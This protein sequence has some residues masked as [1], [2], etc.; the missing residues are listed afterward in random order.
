MLRRADH[1]GVEAEWRGSQ[2]NNANVRI[3]DFAV[4]QEL[5]VHAVALL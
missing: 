1:T 4:G 5:P 2:A 3:D